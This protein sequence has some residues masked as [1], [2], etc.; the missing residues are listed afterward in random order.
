MTLERAAGIALEAAAFLASQ[1]ERMEAFM[2]VS[3]LDVAALRERLGEPGLQ[4]A[5]LGF[6]LTDDELVLDFC[7]DHSCQPRDLHLAQ[8][9]LENL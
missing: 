7:R 6:L 5:I 2:S 4:Q 8:H 9:V 1:P 3:G